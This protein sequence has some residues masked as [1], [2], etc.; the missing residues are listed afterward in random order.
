V[1]EH[2]RIRDPKA[3]KYPISDIAMINC[4]NAA[5]AMV[6]EGP[7]PDLKQAGGWKA[8]IT[9]S[10]P[11]KITHIACVILPNTLAI[12]VT[13]Y[14]IRQFTR[15]PR[16]PPGSPDTGDEKDIEDGEV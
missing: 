4:I 13:A 10:E 1:L 3:G 5:S 7:A 6:T 8:R 9:A 16:P 15:A 2:A 14:E 11:G 12:V